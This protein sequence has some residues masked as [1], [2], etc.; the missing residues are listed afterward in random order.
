[1]NIKT[2]VV[3]AR[4]AL[5]DLSSDSAQKWRDELDQFLDQGM[6]KVETTL[7]DSDDPDDQLD[8]TIGFGIPNYGLWF[9]PKGYNDIC[10][11]EP[12]LLDWFNKQLSVMVWDE[13]QEDP[14][15]NIKMQPAEKIEETQE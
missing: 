2:L 8:V 12:I 9:H 15:H 5:E 3:L 7:Q 13:S 11:A 4:A 10:G 1:M 14:I 6:L